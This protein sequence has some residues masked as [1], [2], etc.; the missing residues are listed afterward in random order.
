MIGMFVHLISMVLRFANG[1]I[2]MAVH[3]PRVF[4]GRRHCRSALFLLA[5][6]TIIHHLAKDR[7]GT[8]GS[9]SAPQVIDI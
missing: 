1:I 4:V 8:S 7:R 2:R 9:S 5:M 6:A 3:L